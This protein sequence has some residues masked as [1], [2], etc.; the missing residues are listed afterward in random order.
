[1][2][3]LAYKINVVLMTDFE[4]YLYILTLWDGKLQSI[5][6]SIIISSML[7]M[8]GHVREIRSK[9]CFAVSASEDF[10]EVSIL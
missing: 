8:I 1:M 7:V 3:N 5:S 6:V 9:Y 4:Y 10:L 2:Y